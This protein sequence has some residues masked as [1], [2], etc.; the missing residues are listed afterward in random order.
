MPNAHVEPKA[1]GLASIVHHR[2]Y[3]VT[4]AAELLRCGRSNAYNLVASGELA[5]TKIGAGKKGIR[6][7]GS[8]LLAFLESRRE[9][10]PMPQGTIKYLKTRVGS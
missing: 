8:D 6:V 4:E 3:L 5:C 2:V 7:L 10:G 1:E 9:G